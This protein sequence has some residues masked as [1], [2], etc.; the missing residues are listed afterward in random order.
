MGGGGPPRRSS[1][2]SRSGHHHYGTSTSLPIPPR[3]GLAYVSY[4]DD[5]VW[6]IQPVDYEKT[7]TLHKSNPRNERF[8]HGRGLKVHDEVEY[9][10]GILAGGGVD[11]HVLSNNS[12]NDDSATS[13]TVTLK[14]I[15][16]HTIRNTSPASCQ[17][18]QGVVARIANDKFGF[19]HFQSPPHAV[20][21]IFFQLGGCVNAYQ[22]FDQLRPGVEVQCLVVDSMNQPDKQVA[23]YVHTTGRVLDPPVSTGPHGNSSAIQK[24]PTP[25]PVST[26]V[27]TS[28]AVPVV[29]EASRFRDRERERDPDLLRERGSIRRG[30]VTR[31]SSTSVLDAPQQSPPADPGPSSSSYRDI[32]SR[33]RDGSDRDRGDRYGSP[34][35]S[36]VQPATSSSS[37]LHEE[38]LFG[39]VVYLGRDEGSFRSVHASTEHK[40]SLVSDALA[41]DRPKHSSKDPSLSAPVQLHVPV[42]SY[43]GI[44]VGDEV[45]CRLYVPPAGTVLSPSEEHDAPMVYQLERLS[46]RDPPLPKSKTWSY[47]RIATLDDQSGRG[48]IVDDDSHAGERVE[49]QRNLI[50]GADR[51]AIRNLRERDNVLYLRMTYQTRLG[52]TRTV[53]ALVQEDLTGGPSSPSRAARSPASVRTRYSAIADP[54]GPPSPR[55]ARSSRERDPYGDRGSGSFRSLGGGPPTAPFTSDSGG[56]RDRHSPPPISSEHESSR[57][58]Y[59]GWITSLQDSFGIL[60][61]KGD[62]KTY[63]FHFKQAVR[64]EDLKKF[65]CVTCLLKPDGTATQVDKLPQRL[66]MTKP[67]W[68]RGEVAELDSSL[69]GGHTPPI[70]SSGAPGGAGGLLRDVDSGETFDFKVHAIKGR[71]TLRVRDRVMFLLVDSP[72]YGN[73]FVAIVDPDVPPSDHGASSSSNTGPTSASAAASDAM[74]S[75][76]PP[77][78]GVLEGWVTSLQDSF[79]ILRLIG[80]RETHFF[81]IKSCLSPFSELR[82]GDCI[83]CAL[84]PDGTAQHVEKLTY[85]LPLDPPDWS[86][87]HIVQMDD[88][89]GTLV[90]RDTRRKYEFKGSVVKGNVHQGDGILYLIVDSPKYGNDFVAAIVSDQVYTTNIT[91]AG[92]V[93]APIMNN[94]GREELTQDPNNDYYG[95][96]GGVKQEE[97]QDPGNQQAPPP[98]DDGPLFGWVV[99]IKGNRGLFRAMDDPGEWEFDVEHEG[100]VNLQ[101]GHEVSCQRDVAASAD[102]YRVKL[103]QFLPAGEPPLERDGIWRRGKIGSV[104]ED[105]G[106]LIDVDNH[107]TVPLQRNQLTTEAWA[108]GQAVAYL[109]MATEDGDIAALLESEHKAESGV[110]TKRER[111]ASPEREAKAARQD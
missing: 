93:A 33:D 88:S 19:I 3:K 80:D 75:R 69:G 21:D 83:R 84:K 38:E 29:A 8:L 12:N 71:Q 51:N 78:K 98:E 94:T 61:L 16:Q 72:K 24:H 40:F 39:W 82:N 62:R 91:C 37:H 6:R 14:E 109:P 58:T 68:R 60:R 55:D 17:L 96:S 59:D 9:D 76:P 28:A 10:R 15:P 23:V 7:I 92:A 13:T 103:L 34:S 52:R 65:D 87:G 36:S 31:A 53:A 110:G 22:T 102:E 25:Q 32:Y 20:G 26:V 63:F 49:L 48:V 30:E 41:G 67:D 46:S 47:G 70:S 43:P 50:A 108:D 11:Q 81:H 86:V 27:S 100:P 73:N 95:S 105:H 97:A 45:T 74:K 64:F 42:G 56:A 18:L 2:G 44:R 90:D 85:Q 4:E 104:K 79:G 57:Q 1:G 99:S 107:E 77:V 35:R 111:E 89:S 66:P 5:Q 106:W 101:E 54:Y